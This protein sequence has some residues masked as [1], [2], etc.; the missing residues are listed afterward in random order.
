M[1]YLCNINFMSQFCFINN[2]QIYVKDYINNNNKQNIFCQNGHEL[3][4]VNGE[5]RKSHFRHKNSCDVGGIPMTLWHVEWQ[6]YFP[7]T[8]VCFSCK[9]NQ[10]K[11]RRADVLLN[12]KKTLEIQHSKYEKEEI[13]N[14]KHDYN[15]HGIDIIWLID[16]NK[17]IDVKILEYSNRVYLEFISDYWKYESFKS[18]DYI[19][20]DINSII[21]KINPNKVKSHMIDVENGKTKEEFIESLKK[22][23][24]IWKNE[25]PE[26]CN[27]F[28]K[29]QG[30]GN[31]KTFGI[32]K[33]L[34]DDDKIHYTNFIYI[35]KQ[36][37]AKHIIKTEFES[38]KDNFQYLKN[39]EITESNKKYII[40]YFNEKSKKNCQ[41]IV[42]TIDSFTYSIGNKNHTHFDKFE[43]LIYSIIDGHI[44]T[45][46]CGAINFGGLSPK[47]NKETLLVI[48]E[49]QD[50]QEHYAK[51][52]VQIMRNKYID[53]F[54]V[55]D[56]LQS[57]TNEKNAFTYFLENEFPLIN[58]IKLDPTNICRRFKHPKLIEFVNFMIPFE[59]YGL[60]EIKPYEEY[61]GEEYNP[62]IFFTSKKRIDS[63]NK[64]A[65]NEENI[66]EEVEK[67]MEYYENEVNENKRF[68][69]DFLIVTPFTTVN[70][71]V[72]ALL[73]AVNI[74][75]K[76]KFTNE[77]ECMKDWK[78]NA[79]IDEYYRYAIFHKSEEGTSIDL[80]ESEYST[81]IVSCH[82]S[83]GDGRKVVFIINFNESAIKKFSQTSNNLVYDSLFHVGITRMKEK[84]Y[85]R[86]ENNNDDIARK[87]N[88]YRQN[89]T[90]CQEIKPNI[91]INNYIKYDEVINNS[92]NKSYDKLFETIIKPTNL[93]PIIENKDEKRIVDMGNHIIRYSALYI[94]ILLEIVNKEKTNKDSEIKKQI[95]AILN[96]VCKSDI[97]PVN[98]IKGYYILLR[99]GDKEIPIIKISNK[100]NDYINYFNAIF[101]ICSHLKVKIKNLLKNNEQLI[102][103][104]IECIILNYM[105]QIVDKKEKSNINI[106][107]IYDIFDLYNNSFESDKINGHDN[108]LCRKHFNK[109][110]KN[111]VKNQ[112]I[113]NIKL[114]L[115]KHFEKINDIKNI[116]SIFHEKYPQINWLMNHTVHYEGNNN[117]IMGGNFN[118][119]GYDENIVIISYIKPQFN[120]LNYN[121]ILV[122]SIFD[123]Y[124][125]NNLKK[126]KKENEINENYKR[127]YGKKV[128]TCIF[129]LDRNEPYYIDWFDAIKNNNEIIKD[130]IYCN[131]IEKYKLETSNLFYFYNYWRMFCP[132]SEKKPSDFIRFLK[133]QFDEIKKKL[134]PF[135]LP[136]K[137]ID[138][139]ISQIE[140]EIE[141]SKGKS[142]KE[143][144]LKNY[145]DI[146]YFTEKLEKKLDLNV[147]RYLEIKIDDDSDNED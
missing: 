60:P 77:P 32:I 112:K 73:L 9:P 108:C 141:F 78:D 81:R 111:D 6:S 42:S 72:D 50:P 139:F 74:F 82:A 49:F 124:L 27:L 115:L 54:I 38:Q 90:I 144:V 65:E 39:I 40:K 34:E 122:N 4:L 1:T 106:V 93:E 67:I 36:H 44:E 129:T 128:I 24:D 3:I 47:L 88:K 96:N 16:G 11:Q 51:A 99:E 101:D 10:I 58:I 59:K 105:I 20:I 137:Y 66:I 70:P 91:N 123:T 43:G 127:F 56:K 114:Y 95:I 30:A 18:Y 131:I 84:L 132:D 120:S 48:D 8:E 116:M 80:S 113:D 68:P 140:F 69:Q 52:I 94:N 126:Y 142:N 109:V 103:C 125:I 107:D 21:Y 145:D 118:I 31:G 7:T 117:F 135:T 25:E 29:Q 15:L 136:V 83:K 146:D 23:I 92:I 35:T 55:G 45:K 133:E 119:I 98:N 87:I 13:D 46:N 110:K 89:D 97:T 76:N 71:L 64:T 37:S 2:E 5:K 138:E 85:I 147:K 12:E 19:F 86:Y 75:W 63:T 53:V 104:P 143:L 57:I 14:R 121:E 17:N 41:I 134:P 102:L 33:M 62:L 61:I 28:I 22:D 26:Q 130:R 79:S 100:G